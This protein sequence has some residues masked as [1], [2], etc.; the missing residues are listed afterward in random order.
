[1]LSKNDLLLLLTELQKNG[2]NVDQQIK[3]LYSNDKIDLNV[4]RFI[5]E[6]RQLDLI[7]FYENLRKNYNNKKSPLYKN[8]M[9]ET[10]EPNDILTTLASLHLQILLFSRKIKDRNLFLKHARAIDITKVL[11]IYYTNYDLSN[12]IK[13]LRMFKADI[14][15]LESVSRS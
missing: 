2:I 7:S 3:D 11:T 8:I 13:L 5:N 15:A 12:C 10:L 1:M 6:H 9:R 4:I 14:K